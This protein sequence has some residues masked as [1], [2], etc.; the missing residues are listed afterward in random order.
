MVVLVHLIFPVSPIHISLKYTHIMQGMTML[1]SNTT[2]SI[3]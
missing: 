3:H 2:M 1:A